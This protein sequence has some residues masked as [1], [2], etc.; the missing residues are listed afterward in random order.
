MADRPGSPDDYHSAWEPSNFD[1]DSDEPDLDPGTMDVEDGE[2][3][4]YSSA[5]S[6]AVHGGYGMD[7]MERS[8]M[9]NRDKKCIKWKNRENQTA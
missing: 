4:G 2:F 6:V 5:N 1:D 7:Y 9:A 8:N 3:S